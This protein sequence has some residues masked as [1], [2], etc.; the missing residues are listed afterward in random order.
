MQYWVPK[1]LTL[2]VVLGLSGC[3]VFTNDAHQKKNYRV[4]E[5]V[6]VPADLEQPYQ[7]QEFK[8]RVATYDNDQEAKS[9]RPPQ[10]VLTLAK[11]SWAEDK[12]DVARIYFDKNDGI[13]HLDEFIWRSVESVISSHEASISDDSRSQGKLTTGWYSLIKAEEGWFWETEK[14]VSRQR[15]EFVLSQ[16]EHQRTASL[17]AKLV[18]YESDEV[19]L[20]DLLQQQLE[21]RAINEVVAEFDYQYRLL[22]VELRKQQGVLSL[23]LGFDL[24]GNAALITLA[25]RSTVM[26]RLSNFLERVNFTVIR[27]DEDSSEVLVRYEA[28]EN[29]VWDS[30]WGEEA[31]T[32]A[33][34]DGDYTI[35]VGTT[36]DEQT[37]LTWFDAE[38]NVLDATM[39]KTLQ[40]GLV[41]ALRNRGLSI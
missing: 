22:Q 40:Q 4:H 21:V 10:Q 6:Q 32:L 25:D 36:D 37:S 27:I 28:P 3:S 24:D 2:G 18:G 8:M 39:M 9:Y 7:D 30:I 34:P 13:E 16:K 31:P 17:Q 26:E 12:E 33:I 15:F 20:N 38:R 5:A 29:S 14:E 41:E 1:A 19:P 23:D 35:K 11:G